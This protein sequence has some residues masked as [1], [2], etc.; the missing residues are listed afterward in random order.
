[1]KKETIVNILEIG[2]NLILKHGYNNVGLNRILDTANI[3]KGL[4]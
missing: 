1:M 4:C 3:P 2:T